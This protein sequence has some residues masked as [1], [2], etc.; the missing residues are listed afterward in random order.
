M[1]VEPG[2]QCGKV[3]LDLGDVT[4]QLGLDFGQVG[5]GDNVLTHSV[6]DRGKGS[7]GQSFIGSSFVK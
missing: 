4:L 6:A 7:F 3:G 1:T 5:F 2:F